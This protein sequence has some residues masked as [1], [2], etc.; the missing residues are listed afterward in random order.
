MAASL[1]WIT[2]LKY[3]GEKPFLCDFSSAPCNVLRHKSWILSQSLGM[4]EWREQHPASIPGVKDYSYS[5]GMVLSHPMILRPSL[6][7]NC[8]GCELGMRAVLQISK[9]G[10]SY[11]EYVSWSFCSPSLYRN[12]RGFRI[13]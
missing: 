11:V 4:I 1:W 12:A 5:V 9:V 10:I 6:N 13:L 8:L 2:S 7:G 3:T